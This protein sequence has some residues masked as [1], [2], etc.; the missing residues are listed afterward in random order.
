MARTGDTTNSPH[1]RAPAE[2]SASASAGDG[3]AT[4][5]F[6]LPHGGRL[7]RTRTLTMRW[8][9]RPLTCHAGDT[10]ASALL[11]HGERVV[12][13]SFKLHRPR[14]ILSAG[15]EEPNALVAIGRGATL[16]PSARATLVRA[17]DGL[18]ARAQNCWP[19]VRFDVGRTLDALAPLWPAGFYNKTFIWPS[20]RTYEH[21]VRRTAGLGDALTEPDPDRYDA[22]TAHCDVLIVGAG[23]AGLH[24]ARRAARAG[25]RVI[26]AEQDFEFGGSL[27][28]TSAAI[29]GMPAADWAASVVAELAANPRVRLLRATTAFGLYDHGH[30]G[31]LE[32]TGDV[33]GASSVRARYWRVSA[34]ATLLATGAIEQPWVFERNDVPGVMLAG[35]VAT[36]ARRFAVAAGR[37]VVL[38]TNNDSTYAAAL[39]LAGA[40]VSVAALLDC[41]AEPDAA[42][43]DRARAAGI[44]VRTHA[45]VQAA[46]GR[47]ALASITTVDLR[48][49]ARADLACDAL[50]VSAGFAPAV[51]LWSHARGRLVYDAAR[52]CFLPAAEDGPIAVAGGVT[53]TA[54]LAE[55]F[56]SADRAVDASIARFPHGAGSGG[57]LPR[58]EEL[59]LAATID[60]RRTA[61]DGRR[62]RQ[63]IDLQ[64][65]VTLADV[66]LALREGFDA[67]EHLKRYTTTGM[68]VDQGKT[69][70]LNALLLVAELTGRAPDTVGTTTFRP[71][72]T[73]V[74]LGA[75]AGRQVGELYAPRRLMPAHAEHVRLDAHFEEAGGW[76]RPGW[77]PR[78]G[79]TAAAAIEREVRAVRSAAGL[80][81]ASPLGKIE[82]EGPD[83]AWFLDRFYVNNVVTLEIG[84]AR[85]GLMLNENGVIVDD[86]TIA[87]L[88]PQHFVITT[89]SGGATRIAAMLDEWR[90]CEWPDRDV[91]V[92]PVTTQWAT[93][94]L[95]GPRARA[96]LSRLPC[97]IDLDPAAF[98]HLAIRTGTLAGVP[99]RVYRVSFSGELGYEINVPARHGAGLWRAL[100]AAGGDDG[101]TPYGLEALLLLRLEKGF[102][103]VGL[104]TDGAT[105]PADVGWGEIALRKKADF[106]GKRSLTRAE[107]VRPDRMQLVGLVPVDGEAFVAGAHLRLDGTAEGSD[108]WITSAASSPT[109][110][111]PI[112][113]A[114]LKGGRSRVGE[115]VAV[116]DLDRRGRARVVATPFYD[117]AGAR[118]HA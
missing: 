26:V 86:G 71:P 77:Y 22:L 94:A 8:N 112:A 84:R 30:A 29:D 59:P 17:R 33:D 41:R 93:V 1:G 73:P 2:A 102:L 107:N 48:T 105:S 96:I 12:G 68:S 31:L 101:L 83:A 104:D 46:H 65:D 54:T 38:A 95:A 16:E 116:H 88:G 91:V 97:N 50:G 75:I 106:V 114:M 27:L 35:A 115:T 18:E 109:L 62:R 39:E 67:I 90:Q 64:H 36:Y 82:V 14:G 100:E 10:L 5:R 15:V 20:W 60:A 49:G 79:E 51:H 3:T 76:M 34:N 56:A 80:F 117:A 98:P 103:H 108:G 81:D 6:R 7:D 4:G 21:I 89:T 19:S 70:N 110:G 24:A 44:D 87:R 69:S 118:L 37:R 72:Y 45:C 11:A 52:R 63:W 58:V 92:T 61:P 13:R 40:G 57:P 9:G 66:D 111:T 74:T 99:A 25:M 43:V 32:R 85:Y 42:L 53:G 28:A 23:A 55:A 78:A 113:L 47:P